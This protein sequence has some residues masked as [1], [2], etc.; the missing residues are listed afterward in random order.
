[1]PG[2]GPLLR[3]GGM[4]MD[5]AL[6]RAKRA[7]VHHRPERYSARRPC[8]GWEGR[9]INQNRQRPAGHDRRRKPRPEA[10]SDGSRPAG[11]QDKSRQEAKAIL[12]RCTT[13]CTSPLGEDVKSDP[14][15]ED[16][17]VE[18]VQKEGEIDVSPPMNVLSW[19][20]TTGTKALAMPG[21]PNQS[22]DGTLLTPQ[23]HRALA[24]GLLANAGKSGF[25]GKKRARR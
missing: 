8:R 6:T 5:E 14:A 22:T 3:P 18:I 9:R 13:N 21:S 1:V 23:K 15:L 7:R 17:V 16:R 11:R 10:I 25:P 2:F 4:A 20:T 19:R 24:Q 12:T